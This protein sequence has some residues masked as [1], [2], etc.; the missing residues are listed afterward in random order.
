MYTHIKERMPSHLA[1]TAMTGINLFTMF[2]AAFFVHGLGVLMQKTFAEQAFSLSA[3][4]LSFLLC[5]GFMMAVFVLYV[6]TR[7][8]R[9]IESR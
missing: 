3:F 8:D 2:G 6:F 9:K 1:G 7:E 4:H 5:A